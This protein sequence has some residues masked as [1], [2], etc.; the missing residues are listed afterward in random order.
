M[1]PPNCDFWNCWQVAA[2]FAGP[3]KTLPLVCEE[4]RVGGTV[5]VEEEVKKIPNFHRTHVPDKIFFVV[6]FTTL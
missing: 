2:V 1:H 6:Y 4:S 3:E 5:S